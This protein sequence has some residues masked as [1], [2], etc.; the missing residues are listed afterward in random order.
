M[1]L[2]LLSAA[3][4]PYLGFIAVDAWMHEKARR[5]PIVE[6]WLHAGIVIVLGSFILAAFLGI[7]ALAG[8]LLALSLPLMAAESW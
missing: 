1:R 6:Q 3:L 5:V 8:I 4:T 2:L 7:N